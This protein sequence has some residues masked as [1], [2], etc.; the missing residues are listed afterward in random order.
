M[1]LVSRIALGTGFRGSFLL[2]LAISYLFHGLFLI[3]AKH[4]GTVPVGGPMFWGVAFVATGLFMF[5]GVAR[6]ADRYHYTAA[7]FLMILWSLEYFWRSIL[8]PYA[9]ANG[10]MWLFIAIG[11]TLV[12]NWPE[13][14]WVVIKRKAA[15]DAL[16]QK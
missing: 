4:T 14:M 6:R 8:P 1:K 10:L 9:W 5:T 12:S 7:V 2:F 16:A 15:R 13:P 3:A 11:V